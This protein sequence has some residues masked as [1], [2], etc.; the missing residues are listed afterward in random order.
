M[1][2]IGRGSHA[3][4]SDTPGGSQPW[5]SSLMAWQVLSLLS[6]ATSAFFE[7]STY[8]TTD[9][10]VLSLSYNQLAGTIPDEI[11]NLSKLKILSVA[12]NNITGVIPPWVGNLSHL[13]ELSVGTNNLG[14]GIPEELSRLA[15]LEVL[16][17]EDNMLLGII[18]ASLYNLS[19]LQVL[20]AEAN[21]LQGSLPSDIGIRLP[22]LRSIYLGSNKLGGPIPASLSNASRLSIINIPDNAFTGF[23]P[24]DLGRLKYLSEL[25]LDRNR[26]EAD[27]V[28]GWEFLTSLKNCS[29]LKRLVML[30]NKLG[31]VLP[32]SIANL[33]TQLE[34]LVMASNQISGS[35]PSGIKNLVNLKA[36]GMFENLLTGTI[37]EGVGN[38]RQLRRL[39]LFNN[40]F[41]GF[42]PSSLGNL[43]QL[44]TLDLYVNGLQGPI[45][46]SL[47]NLQQLQVLDLSQNNLSGNIPKEIVSLPFLSDSINLSNNSLVGPLPEEVGSLTNLRTFAVSGN[48]LSGNI[49]DAIGKCEVLAFLF[50]NN[51]FF[52]GSIPPS[53][54]NIKGLTGLF[55]SYNHLTGTI[56]SSL[57]SIKELRAL[58][59]SHNY[60][61]GSIPQSLEGLNFS[62]Y[63]NFEDSN[64]AGLKYLNASSGLNLSFN[65]LEGK[66]P[67][68]GIFK[69]ETAVSLVGNDG[70]C[71]GVPELNLPKC[72]VKSS[73][74]KKRSQLLKFM[75]PTVV[76]IIFFLILFSFA[77]LYWKQK[78]K[79]QTSSVQLLEDQNFRVSYAE[80]VKATN[81][82]SSTKLIGLGRYGSVYKGIMD[83]GNTTVAIKVFNLLHR[84]ASRSFIAECEALRNIRHRNL[85]K[86]LTSCSSIDFQGN[87]FKALVFEF[88]PNGSLETWLHPKPVEDLHVNSLSWRKRLDIA[89]DIADALDY[90]HHNCQPPIVHC[91][92]KPGNVLLDN[93]MCAHVGDFGL[94]RFL[95]EGTGGHI[96]S[97]STT[98]GIKGTIG[99]VAPE[100]GA[101]CHVSTSGDV[102]SY[103]IL[104]LEM[105]T[106]KS[107]V[108]DM[109]QDGLSLCKFVEMAFPDGVMDIADPVLMLPEP[110][111]IANS[112][113]NG[114]DAA[115][116]IQEC[117]INLV[118]VGLSCAN[119]SRRE[120]M[121][122]RDAATMM[123][124][125]RDAYN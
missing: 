104:L 49:P 100:Y 114:S 47:G 89:V 32:T 39:G 21:Q 84:S 12:G 76:T 99:Y 16:G 48:K 22:D 24:T 52:N 117:M 44:I 77:L 115:W 96:Q 13:S 78:P 113:R 119:Q 33:S 82:F 108:D 105:F 61:T 73:E 90:L 87:D 102:Y 54:G 122:M 35:I 93:D 10:T 27:N 125:I 97:S 91:D 70:L 69:N 60:L 30:D 6:L 15:R 19:S 110:S 56:P 4:A 111:N 109:F 31:G 94:A 2:A 37:P 106:G 26:I 65:R 18:P 51:N 66:V 55:L 43:T 14:G 8:Q 68:E 42:I 3:P 57:S 103:G 25:F 17:L 118:K 7:E 81:G 72:P 59:L 92:L 98:V 9:S 20:S 74:N 121:S 112:Q 58:D 62:S 123:H 83:D 36:L 86:I 63:L 29:Y 75:I 116:K 71:G 34:Y 50:L 80:L 46:P 79:Q 40:R 124:R 23:M 38:L 88:M 64:D 95:N 67:A 11:S 5:S 120:R 28:H 101:G 41:T 53:L 107:P 45:P 85:I 1:S